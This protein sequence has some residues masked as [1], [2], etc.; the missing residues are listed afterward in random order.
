[1]LF[2]VIGIVFLTEAQNTQSMQNLGTVNVDELSNDQ[3]KKFLNQAESSG[4]S[5]QQMEVLAKARG[6]SASQI[7]KLRQRIAEVRSGNV[8]SDAVQKDIQTTRVDPLEEGLNPLTFLVEE[9]PAQEKEQKVFGMSF[10]FQ[11]KYFL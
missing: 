6:M 4:Y 5:E 8:S 10:F 9:K 2:F 11:P 3:I 1:M 7:A